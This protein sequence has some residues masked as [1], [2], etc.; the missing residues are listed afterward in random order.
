MIVPVGAMPWR[1]PESAEDE[2][3]DVGQDGELE[4][5]LDEPQREDTP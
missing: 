4:V 1:A 3:E 2:E 5:M